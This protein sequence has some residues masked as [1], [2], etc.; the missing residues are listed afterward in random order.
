M[1]TVVAKIT[2]LKEIRLIKMY[3]MKLSKFFRSHVRH[4]HRKK[5]QLQDR[6]VPPSYI[7]EAAIEKLDGI[8]KNL[9]AETEFDIWC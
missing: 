4:L 1:K 3:R 8:Q 6:Y 9:S 5:R 7:G 2:M